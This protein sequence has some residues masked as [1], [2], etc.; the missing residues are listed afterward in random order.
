MKTRLTYYHTRSLFQGSNFKNFVH[1]YFEDVVFEGCG[2]GN[3][4]PSI[5]ISNWG[6]VKDILPKSARPESVEKLTC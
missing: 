3:S 1:K 5:T 4:D 2:S 6:E